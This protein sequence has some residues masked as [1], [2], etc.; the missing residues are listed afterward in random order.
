MVFKTFWGTTHVGSVIK[1]KHFYDWNF[2]LLYKN[3]LAFTTYPALIGPQMLW[4]RPQNLPFLMFQGEDENQRAVQD[5]GIPE[6]AEEKERRERKEASKRA[7]ER[8]RNRIH[9]RTPIV[10]AQV[11]SMPPFQPPAPSTASATRASS[12][13]TSAATASTAGETAQRVA[14]PV[15]D[16]WFSAYDWLIAFVVLAIA[17]LVYRRF[18]SWQL[19]DSD[20][21]DWLEET[22]W[23]LWCVF[24]F[25]KKNSE[26]ILF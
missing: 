8:F 3:D 19:Y 25:H 9:A 13:T 20:N 14:R 6:T 4:N 12:T 22:L 16:N 17:V 23:L 11:A 15:A 2:S 10:V 18:W 26:H 21:T 5:S 24:L 1:S 7:Q